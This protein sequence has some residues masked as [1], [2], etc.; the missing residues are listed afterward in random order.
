MPLMLS[1][2]VL[3]PLERL[4]SGLQHGEASCIGQPGQ[5]L[6]SLEATEDHLARTDLRWCSRPATAASTSMGSPR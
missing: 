1:T 6:D 4:R 5:P 3:Q 2:R